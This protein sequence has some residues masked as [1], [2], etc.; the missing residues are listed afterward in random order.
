M[1]GQNDEVFVVIVVLYY[2]KYSSTV[3]VFQSS[4]HACNLR[5]QSSALKS[6]DKV[7]RPINTRHMTLLGTKS[8]TEV[9]STTIVSAFVYCCQLALE[10]SSEEA[11]PVENVSIRL[12]GILE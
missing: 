7:R 9:S 11:I 2:A 5:V 10:W 3:M 12:L 1:L 8:G 6:V 4:L